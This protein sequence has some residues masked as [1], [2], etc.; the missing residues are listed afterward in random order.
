[1]I[2]LFLAWTSIFCIQS[3]S[4]GVGCGRQAPA[5]SP[6][7]GSAKVRIIKGDATKPHSWP[8]TVSFQYL[9]SQKCGGSLLRVKENVE[10]S[11]IVLRRSIAFK[12]SRKAGL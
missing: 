3:T 6:A 12:R 7:L 2:A 5:Y 8:W 10:Q 1:V 4:A 11:D 9:Q